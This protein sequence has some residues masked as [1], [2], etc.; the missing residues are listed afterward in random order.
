MK[1]LLALS[2]LSL[3]LVL[4]ACG[5]D[6]KE[7]KNTRTCTMNED[8]VESEII[9]KHDDK[10]I[11]KTIE[12]SAAQDV[13]QE[14]TDEMLEIAEDR[15]ES[16]IIPEGESI[17][18]VDIKFSKGEKDTEVKVTMIMDLDKITEAAASMSGEDYSQFKGMKVDDVID[19]MK[20][21]AEAEG[22]TLKCE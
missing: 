16:M 15:L 20:E 21:N 14:V 18:G 17:E 13:G 22:K 11:V 12:A 5:G 2:A 9:F 1:K 10:E 4:T 6:K 3:L 7:E 19:A 8:G